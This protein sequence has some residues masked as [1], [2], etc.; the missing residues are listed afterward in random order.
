MALVQIAD[1]HDRGRL[2]F[3]RPRNRGRADRVYVELL[4]PYR[5]PRQLTGLPGRQILPKTR[6]LSKVLARGAPAEEHTSS[7]SVSPTVVPFTRRDP[8]A[9]A[10]YEGGAAEVPCPWAVTR[11]GPSR[12]CRAPL[13]SKA[14]R[15]WSRRPGR[16]AANSIPPPQD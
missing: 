13:S 16:A 9:R 10:R 11:I 4:P 5:R 1:R 14:S 3:D 12:A 8:T 6:S 7:I 2:I 15:S